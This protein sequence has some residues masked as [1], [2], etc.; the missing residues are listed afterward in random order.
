M[1]RSLAIGMAIQMRRGGFELATG[2]LLDLTF[3]AGNTTKW[4]SRRAGENFGVI[5]SGTPRVLGA[6]FS[7][8]RI[9]ERGSATFQLSQTGGSFADWVLLYPNASFVITTPTGVVTFTVAGLKG[10]GS[11]FITWRPTTAEQ[12]ILL[13]VAVGHSVTL[14]ISTP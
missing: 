5:T 12:I 10:V 6:G 11:S 2:T 9:W 1:S 8:D 13:A 14:V 7:I 4:Y 3:T